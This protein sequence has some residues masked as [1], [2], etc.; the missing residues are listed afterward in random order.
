METEEGNGPEAKRRKSFSK[1]ETLQQLEELGDNV[2]RA[3]SE[4]VSDLSPFD[5]NDTNV[6][7]YEDRIE[8]LARVTKALSAK[9]YRLK[10]DVKRTIWGS[11]MRQNRPILASKSP[12]MT[13]K[14]VNMHDICVTYPS[15]V[16]GSVLGRQGD[17]V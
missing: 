5:V 17:S 6:E 16:F 1:R 12:W 8:K 3:A 4:M 13:P 15:G 2:Q 7:A 10:D 9:I 11:N 14:Q